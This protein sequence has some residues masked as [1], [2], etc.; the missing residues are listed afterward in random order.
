M[1]LSVNPS[2]TSA[3]NLRGSAVSEYHGFIAEGYKNLRARVLPL[4]SWDRGCSKIYGIM[5]SSKYYSILV[6][7]EY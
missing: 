1:F 6:P 7:Y 3:H 2:R 5:D 4:F